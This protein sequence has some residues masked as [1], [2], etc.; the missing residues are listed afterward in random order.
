MNKKS[1][2]TGRRLKRM[3][4][5]KAGALSVVSFIA[6]AG[7]LLITATSHVNAAACTPPATTYGT[8]TMT[9]N[10]TSATVYNVWVRMQAPAATSDSIMLQ[11]DGSTC[12]SVGGNASMPLNAWTW[13]NYQNGS[14]TSTMQTPSLT[15]GSHSLELIGTEPGVEIDNVLLLSDASCVPTGTGT[16]CTP[17][18]PPTF[19]TPSVSA[20]ATSPTSVAL[21]LT[22]STETNG[23]LTGYTIF[24]NGTKLATVGATATSYTDNSVTANTTYSY[25]VQ[26]YDGSGNVSAVS[27]AANVTTPA[28]L[29][30]M[31]PGGG[32]VYAPGYA[33][34]GAASVTTPSTPTNVNATATSA[35]SVSLSWTG[36]TDTGGPGLAGYYVIRTQGTTS[37]TLGQVNSTTYKYIDTTALANTL[38]TYTVE[39]FDSATPPDV[40]SGASAIVTTPNPP[41]TTPPT[42]PTNLT[43]IAASS[44]QIN[45]SWTAST[46]S[47]G[48]AGYY[49]YRAVGA[50]SAASSYTKI[51]TSSTNSYGD[52]GLTASTT[53][54]YYVV[55]VDSAGNKSPVS[56]TVSATTQAVAT[57]TA[58]VKGTVTSSRNKKPIASAYV[59]TGTKGTASGMATAYTNS[60]GQYALMNIKPNVRN[61]YYY[62]ASGYRSQSSTHTV[63]I[64]TTIYNVAL[65][66]H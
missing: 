29:V 57:A 37:T 54:S 62:S 21:T 46:D 14:T 34:P 63:P 31:I 51:G 60:A 19:T 52:T 36:S 28:P 47:I 25:T 18:I 42:H 59:H 35:T 64:G 39:A 27:A 1:F 43:A 10:V 3:L 22:G 2:S 55:A 49:I 8:D 66:P 6:I 17:V 12:Y 4:T 58:T 26:A 48:V 7:F 40:S 15:A 32:C 41:D 16:N 38:Y 44:T 33:C 50:S 23:T 53:Y 20:I 61:S 24:K 30:G 65:R 9:V 56:A 45:L 5:S 13:V 11:V